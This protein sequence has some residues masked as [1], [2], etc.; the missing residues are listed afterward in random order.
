MAAELRKRC[1]LGET[2]TVRHSVG[3]HADTTERAGAS[4]SKYLS[5]TQDDHLGQL[6]LP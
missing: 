5:S 2:S 1:R 4:P 3:S 6:T